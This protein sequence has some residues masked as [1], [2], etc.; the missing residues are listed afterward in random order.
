VKTPCQKASKAFFKGFFREEKKESGQPL[1]NPRGQ[2]QFD[3]SWHDQADETKVREVYLG[4]FRTNHAPQEHV[5]VAPL[6]PQ[7]HDRHAV[8]IRSYCSADHVAAT[9]CIGPSASAEGIYL[10]SPRPAHPLPCLSRRPFCLHSVL[11][12]FC[13]FF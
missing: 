5:V 2:I 7:K 6:P 1:F 9:S 3:Q 8:A 4:V 11:P 13:P 12:F 10:F